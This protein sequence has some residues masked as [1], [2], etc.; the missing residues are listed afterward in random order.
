MTP[1]TPPKETTN[2]I[3]RPMFVGAHFTLRLNNLTAFGVT[4]RTLE[5]A[6]GALRVNYH[7][8][9]NRLKALFVREWNRHGSDEAKPTPED[10]NRAFL[11]KHIKVRGEIFLSIKAAAKHYNIPAHHIRSR[12]KKL[13]RPVTPAAIDNIFDYSEYVKRS[14]FRR[15][16]KTYVKGVQY[17]SLA[18][19]CRANRVDKQTVSRKLAKLDNPAQTE[20]DALFD[21]P[22]THTRNPKEITVRGINYPSIT[23][24]CK[25]LGVGQSTVDGRLKRI[26]ERTPAHIDACFEK[27]GANSHST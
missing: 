20:I 12:L 5:E 1:D 6:T 11:P 26:P 9:A 21:A 7:G 19:A 27:K 17:P 3:E 22:N 15:Y 18:H 13:P 16:Q 24:A 14:S 25:A 4:Y 10:I 23:A 2:E 8:A